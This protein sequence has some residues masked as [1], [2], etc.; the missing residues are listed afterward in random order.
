M[1]F[2][3]YAE[4]VNLRRSKM[5]CFYLGLQLAACCVSYYGGRGVNGNMLY[6]HISAKIHSSSEVEGR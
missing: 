2:I 6:D 1:W 4:A 5:F 3:Q